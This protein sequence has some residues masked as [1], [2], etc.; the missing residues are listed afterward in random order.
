[1]S[2]VFGRLRIVR[3]APFAIPSVEMIADFVPEDAHQPGALGR[4]TR[5]AILRFERREKRLL[6]GIFGVTCVAKLPYRIVIKKISVLIDPTD[7]IGYRSLYRACHRAEDAL[8]LSDNL[9]EDSF[10]STPD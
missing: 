9:I 8:K 6:Y 4:S 3:D 2:S 10:I 7:W 1:M 5:E